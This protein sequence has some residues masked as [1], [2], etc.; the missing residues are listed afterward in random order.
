MIL[1]NYA[2][3]I[4]VHPK[5][6]NDWFNIMY[7]D[8]FDYIVTP[9][10]MGMATYS[11]GGFMST[12]PY[13]SSAAYIHKMSNYCASCRFDPL[14]KEGEKA[15]PFN[16]LYWDFIDRHEDKLKDNPRMSV[17]VS[18]KNKMETSLLNTYK[19]QAKH[20]IKTTL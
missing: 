2:N 12:K 13:I 16:S 20:H 15:C 11:D 7:I 4:G 17:M 9:N 6:L 3:L 10:V 19:K 18:I 14:I 1:G 8:S 5:E